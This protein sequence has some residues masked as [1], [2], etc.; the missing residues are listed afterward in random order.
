MNKFSLF[1]FTGLLIVLCSCATINT[2]K[3]TSYS[4]NEIVRWTDTTKLSWDDFTGVPS[5]D[6]TLHSQMIVLT[7]AKFKEPTYFDSAAAT[8]DCF[9]VKNASWIAKGKTKKQLLAYYQTLFDIYELS[10]RNLRKTFADTSFKVK[11]P[12]G[13][14]NKIYQDHYTTL[15]KTISQYRSET[16]DGVKTKK[17][18]EWVEKI[19]EEL[20]A[21]EAYKS[22]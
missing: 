10:V 17:L 21:L 9:M 19:T 11:D 3:E 15:A 14:F 18:M 4:P 8:V 6:S 22:K 1:S 2:Q 16:E 12:V 5:A 20:T 13:L 7:P